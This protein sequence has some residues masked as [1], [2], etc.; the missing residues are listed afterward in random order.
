MPRQFTATEWKNLARGQRV[1]AIQ[2]EQEIEKNRTTTMEAAF[3]R[4]R[5]T[6]L[7]LAALCEEWAKRAPPG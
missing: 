2:T 1:L 5:E 7:E 3:I 4:A 6:H